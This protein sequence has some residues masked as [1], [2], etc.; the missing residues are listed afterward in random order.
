M[1]KFKIVIY[2]PTKSNPVDLFWYSRDYLAGFGFQRGSNMTVNWKEVDNML[3]NSAKFQDMLN[4]C[5]LPRTDVLMSSPSELYEELNKGESIEAYF[6]EYSNLDRIREVIK[7]VYAAYDELL[8]KL[9]QRLEEVSSEIKADVT[10]VDG[11]Y[12][13]LKIEASNGSLRR[14]ELKDIVNETVKDSLSKLDSPLEYDCMMNG[15]KF[16]RASLETNNPDILVID[17]D[18]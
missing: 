8:K 1:K 7:D 16:F 5:G 15:I 11:G 17:D 12:L 2:G 13:T 14:E 10:K 3:E 9:I 4:E 6:A 18:Y